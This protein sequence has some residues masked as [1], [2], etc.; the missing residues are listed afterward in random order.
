MRK[1]KKLQIRP[2]PQATILWKANIGNNTFTFE[3]SKG[4]KDFINCSL[5]LFLYIIEIYGISYYTKWDP[6]K[7][8]KVSG[9][10]NNLSQKNVERVHT[11]P[12]KSK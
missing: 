11:A 6:I 5:T 7:G 2:S 9:S 10:T 12:I 1:E 3:N 8:I 4:I